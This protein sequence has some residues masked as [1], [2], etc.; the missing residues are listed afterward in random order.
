MILTS[1]MSSNRK[2]G[3]LV[4]VSRK[5]RIDILEA[6]RKCRNFKFKEQDLFINDHLS[7]F[8]RKLFAITT[9]KKNELKYCFLWTRNGSIFMRENKHSAAFKIE[10]EQC[11]NNLVSTASVNGSVECY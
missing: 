5:T 11:L 9:L 1:A 8:N 6:K 2:D 4:A 10:S 3:K 7:P